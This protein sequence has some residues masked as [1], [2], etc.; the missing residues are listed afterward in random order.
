MQQ[1][2]ILKIADTS[3]QDVRLEPR[4]PRRKRLIVIGI[5][6]AVVVAGWMATPVVQRWATASVSV[7]MDRLRTA[8]VT[9]GDLVRDVSVQGR[10]VAAVSPTLYATASGTI[11]LNVEAGERVL[12][13]QVLASVDSPELTNSLQQAESALAQKKIELERQRIESRQ[14]MLEKRKA[15]DLA[16]VA[17]VA[18][19]REKRRRTISGTPSSRT[20]TP[21][22]T[23]TCSTNGS[24]SS[25]ARPSSRST[26]KSSWS[27]TCGARST[28]C[29]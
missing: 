19:N 14:Q 22:R 18:A 26:A 8:T 3:A 6:V 2:A 9:R 21:L 29:R 20:S 1:G 4:N 23:R 12:A 15:A 13:G 16:D 25:C 11:T 17:L 10:I 24:S 5:I 7:P 27:R 28:T